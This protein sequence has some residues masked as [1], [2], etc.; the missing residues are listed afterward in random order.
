[1]VQIFTDKA[2]TL[3]DL[4]REKNES[5]QRGSID[6]EGNIEFWE[7]TPSTDTSPA[8]ETPKAIGSP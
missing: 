8:D 3:A 1:M 4:L 2:T 7:D 6:T 5:I